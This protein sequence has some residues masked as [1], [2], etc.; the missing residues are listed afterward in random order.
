MSDASIEAPRAT[1]AI[2]VFNSAATLSRCLDSAAAQTW[3][4]IEILVTDDGSTDASAAIASS[5]AA[6]DA[7]I[8][9]IRL[10]RNGGKS[11]AMNLMAEQARGTWLAVL[12]ADDAYRPERLA[13]LIG[14]ADAAGVEMAADN[15]SYIDAGVGRSVQTAF[16]PGAPARTVGKSDLA[17]NSSSFA[18]FD[19]GIL[20]PVIRRD[21]LIR[22]ALRYH[23]DA[24]LAEDFYYLM[25][26][27]VA[28]GRGRIV[29][30]PLYEWTMPFSATTRRWT[31][32]GNGAWRYDYRNALRSNQHF[33]AEMTRAG[34][35][36]MASMLRAR[37]RQYI[38]MLHYIDAQRAA[39][40]G[41]FAAALR[42]IALHPSTWRLLAGR[43]AG[44]GA[45]VIAGVVARNK[46]QAARQGVAR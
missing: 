31:Q 11:R 33:L 2:P 7:R 17:A 21:F 30:E 18:T 28:G 1:I 43:V 24:T 42:G 41:R 22:H 5:H 20:K 8:R 44:R 14:A 19:F 10:D 4:D 6:R 27:F 46:R 15:I 39:A 34:E 45:R 23:E 3:R 37:Q 36:E 35:T 26:F 40:D 9:V 25:K 13:T 29:S 32:T 38:S 16:D 12:D